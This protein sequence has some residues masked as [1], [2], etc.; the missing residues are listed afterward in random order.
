MT[1]RVPDTDDIQ[2]RK[3]A[4]LEDITASGR[5]AFREATTLLEEVH[6]VHQALPERAL[7][8]VDLSVEWLGRTLKAR[9]PHQGP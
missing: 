4:H 5:G 8:E 2:A 6:L 7:D 1:H 9:N 3:D